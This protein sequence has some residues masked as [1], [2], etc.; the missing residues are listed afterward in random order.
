MALI[1]P[2][3]QMILLDGLLVNKL[4]HIKWLELWLLNKFIEQ[5]QFYHPRPII[6]IRL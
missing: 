4:G 6:A 5:Y 2:M 1:K 3:S